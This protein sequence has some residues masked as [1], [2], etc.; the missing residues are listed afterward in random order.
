[1]LGNFGINLASTNNKGAMLSPVMNRAQMIEF[2]DDML[3]REQSD[4]M[5]PDIDDLFSLYRMIRK[6][7]VLAT[8]EYGSGWSTLV[9]AK[10]LAENKTANNSSL[11][12]T[13]RHP[14]PYMVMSVDASADFLRVAV[15]RLVLAG[16]DNHVVP[17]LSQV[18][19]TQLDSRVCHLFHSV[20]S[21]MADFVYLDG[22]D[23]KQVQGA[24]NGFSVAFDY[25]G[26]PING[27]PVSADILNLEHFFWPGTTVLIDGRGCNADFIRSNLKRNWKY[28]YSKK[29][30]Q[31]TFELREKPWGKFSKALL[32]HKRLPL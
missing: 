20:P 10:A 16:L 6:R 1:V 5:P 21:F 15:N 23:P 32:R 18:S 29:L 25:T 19:M 26:S 17:V 31:H 2:I 8:L 27:L 3:A 4:A 30:D 12:E 7:R 9:I 28:T 13:V 11:A 24:V 14:N 22:P